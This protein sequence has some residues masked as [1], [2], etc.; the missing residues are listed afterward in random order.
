MLPFA[1]A[2]NLPV[3]ATPLALMAHSMGVDT[4]GLSERQAAEASI[5]AV[6][7]LQVA[8][9]VPAR[10][11]ETELD[12][13]L[14]PRIAEHAMGDRGLYFNPRRTDRVEAVLQ[15]LEEAW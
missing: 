6:R 1:M 5:Q 11:R 14:L 9:R 13:A 2:Y 4:A 7:D 3:A 10:L 8:A 12:R 15:L